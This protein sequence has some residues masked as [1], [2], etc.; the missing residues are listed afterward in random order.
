MKN[1]KEREKKEKIPKPKYNMWQNTWFM[2]SRAW[3]LKEKKVLV[4]SFLIACFTVMNNIINLYIS[5]IILS[6]IERKAPISE[7][8]LTIAFLIGSMMLVCASYAYVN[9]N[10][11]FG[12]ITIRVG[13]IDFINKKSATTSYVNVEDETFIKLR[14]KA[15]E[16]TSANFSATEA[17]WSTLTSLLENSIGFIIYVLLL[18]TVQPVLLVV[19]LITTILS[20]FINNA[21]SSYRYQHKEEEAEYVQKI[22]Y[23]IKQAN[24]WSAA[25]DIRI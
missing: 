18:T 11:I 8:L 19:I 25:K 15:A 13:I 10:V 20:Y 21:C 14:G 7:L 17:I 9:E 2:I 1:E 4:L 6:V 22:S 23:V 24:N 16:S 3:K 5:P 12:R